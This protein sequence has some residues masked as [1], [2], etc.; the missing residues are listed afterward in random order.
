MFELR[1]PVVTLTVSTLANPASF[2]PHQLCP[3][4]VVFCNVIFHLSTNFSFLSPIPLC[5]SCHP[6]SLL[7]SLLLL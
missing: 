3:S 1:G 5:S 7:L 4:V 6:A 2:L